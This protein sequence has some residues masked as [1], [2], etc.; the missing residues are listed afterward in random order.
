MAVNAAEA[1]QSFAG[2]DVLSGL[3]HV[4]A[5][6]GYGYVADGVDFG[7]ATPAIATG[8]TIL[9]AAAA[10]GGA[11]GIIQGAEAGNPAAVAGSVLIIAAAAASQNL[12]GF[13]S[14]SQSMR[15]NAASALAAAATGTI[16]ADTL[17][18]GDVSDALILSLGP[19]L[20]TV[21]GGYS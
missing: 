6:V 15:I 10:V 4:A 13:D 18:K 1:G 7:G 3:L 9:S 12:A 16:V 5:A 11:S 19:L 8:R 20:A 17:A 2:G 21:A 14:S